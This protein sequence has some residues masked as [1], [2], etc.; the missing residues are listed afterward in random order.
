MHKRVGLP[1]AVGKG[2]KIRVE[3]WGHLIHLNAMLSSRKMQ[4]GFR[5]ALVALLPEACPRLQKA[6]CVWTG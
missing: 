2:V 1:V 4:S 5:R 3:K 6:P